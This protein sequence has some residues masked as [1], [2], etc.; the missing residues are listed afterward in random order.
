ML[1]SWTAP[2]NRTTTTV[3]AQPCGACAMEKRVGQHP[4]QEDHRDEDRD[5][6]EPRDQ[7]QRIAA[8][9]DRPSSAS[10]IKVRKRVFRAARPRGRPGR[11]AGRPG[12][13]PRTTA[14]RARTASVP[15]GA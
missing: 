6:P 3:L 13:S 11:T 7:P 8:E 15:A 9:A 14:G 10:P 12:E 2:M 1:K 4:D 5:H